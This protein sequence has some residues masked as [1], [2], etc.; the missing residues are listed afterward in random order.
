MNH[1][2]QERNWQTETRDS[3][4]RSRALQRSED[5]SHQSRARE[6]QLMDLSNGQEWTTCREGRLVKARNVL[7]TSWETSIPAKYVTAYCSKDGQRRPVKLYMTAEQ[8]L[9]CARASNG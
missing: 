8:K 3:K 1:A 9:L 7:K 2:A 4:E 5:R 6:M